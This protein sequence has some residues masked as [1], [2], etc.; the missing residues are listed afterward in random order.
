MIPKSIKVLVKMKTVSFIL[1]E[2]KIQTFWPTQYLPPHMHFPTHWNSEGVSE[3]L[4]SL[5]FADLQGRAVEMASSLQI[6]WWPHKCMITRNQDRSP[7]RG[8]LSRIKGEGSAHLK[9]T[10]FAGQLTQGLAVDVDY[11]PVKIS[12]VFHKHAL[13]R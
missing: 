10:T 6:V 5:L 7:L 2:K 12:Y 11:I 13:E 8:C 9:R 1:W 3:I 4:L